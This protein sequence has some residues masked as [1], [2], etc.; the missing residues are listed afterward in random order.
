MPKWRQRDS[1][2]LTEN[3][4]RKVKQNKK[5]SVSCTA[6]QDKRQLRSYLRVLAIHLIRLFNSLAQ[7]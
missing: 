5:M 7:L 3:K 2:S 1:E 6:E 4:E